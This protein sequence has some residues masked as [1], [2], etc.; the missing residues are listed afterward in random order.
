MYQTHLYNTIF[1]TGSNHI[2]VVWTPSDVQNGSFMPANQRMIGGDASGLQ[3][4]KTKASISISQA[5]A[6]PNLVLPMIDS[7]F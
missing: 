6:T 5:N 1:G 7:P 3:Q 2:V 4:T